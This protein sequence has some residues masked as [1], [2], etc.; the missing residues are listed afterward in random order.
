MG[1]RSHEQG[2]TK[3]NGRKGDGAIEEGDLVVDGAVRF[4]CG[5]RGGTAAV[6]A[7]AGGGS[8]GGGGVRARGP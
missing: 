7:G 2:T 5:G 3:S 8:S 1:V 4:S 6:A